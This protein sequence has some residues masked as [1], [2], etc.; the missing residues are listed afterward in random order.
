[1]LCLVITNTPFGQ[2]KSC[3][4][5]NESP[6]THSLGKR[7]RWKLDLIRIASQKLVSPEKKLFLFTGITVNQIDALFSA[8]ASIDLNFDLYMM[9]Y[10]HDVFDLH[11]VFFS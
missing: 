6:Q 5:L 1:M 3:C 11:D 9:F 2:D 10:L 7:S 8:D 4:Q